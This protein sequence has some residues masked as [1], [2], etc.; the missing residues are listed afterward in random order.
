MYRILADLIRK[1]AVN[2]ISSDCQAMVWRVRGKFHLDQSTTSMLRKSKSALFFFF[3]EIV[4]ISYKFICLSEPNSYSINGVKNRRCT[5]RERFS[6]RW[7]T[8]FD[9]AKTPSGKRSTQITSN[10]SI[11]STMSRHWTLKRNSV[12]CKSISMLC[13]QKKDSQTFHR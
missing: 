13:T 11:T 7:A 5:K 12:R 1:C 6:F 4:I 8:T 10:C 3:F 9:T 2:S